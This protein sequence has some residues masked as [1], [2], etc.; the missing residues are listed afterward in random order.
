MTLQSR[1]I[2]PTLSQPQW[3]DGEVLT[4]RLDKR[5]TETGITSETTVMTFNH[6]MTGTTA[7]N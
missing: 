2:L 3:H 6:A 4:R 1:R 7:T 5:E